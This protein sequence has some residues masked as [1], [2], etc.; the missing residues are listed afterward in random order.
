MRSFRT[1]SPTEGPLSDFKRTWPRIVSS[2]QSIWAS[3][4]P[5]AAEVQCEAR[6]KKAQIREVPTAVRQDRGRPSRDSCRYHT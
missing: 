4:E 3:Y 1:D 5:S 6:G 2:S